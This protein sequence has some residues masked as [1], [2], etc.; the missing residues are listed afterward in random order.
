[1]APPPPPPPTQTASIQRAHTGGD[2][3]PLTV[4]AVVSRRVAPCANHSLPVARSTE[5]A[6]RQAPPSALTLSRRSSSPISPSSARPPQPLW[7]S[8]DRTSPAP[9]LLKVKRRS[10]SP[11]LSLSSAVHS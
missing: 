11:P 8:R 1:P 7:N 10:P 3:L 5:N 6:S 9:C 4:R 2:Q